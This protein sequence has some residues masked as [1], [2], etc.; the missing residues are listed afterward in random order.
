MLFPSRHLPK[1]LDF[2][3]SPS[4]W[5]GLT[6]NSALLVLHT[7]S[8]T[9]KSLLSCHKNEAQDLAITR[10]VAK[11]IVA[12]SQLFLDSGPGALKEV[13]PIVLHSPYKAASVY[14]TLNRENPSEE[15]LQALETL[16]AALEVKNRKWRVAGTVSPV[17]LFG[18]V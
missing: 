10:A 7:T 6:S 5:H 1:V 18:I 3:L 8:A 14:I 2:L 17:L 16:K 15:S 11:N 13:S 4:L 9:L 12:R